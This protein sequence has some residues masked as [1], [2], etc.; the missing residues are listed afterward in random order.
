[1]CIVALAYKIGYMLT[2]LDVVLLSICEF[3]ELKAQN[4]DVYI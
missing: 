2:S 1:M 3:G 4:G